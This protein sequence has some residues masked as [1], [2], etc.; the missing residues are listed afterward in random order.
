MSKSW[1]IFLLVLISVCLLP[2]KSWGQK[3]TTRLADKSFAEFAYME[4]IELYEYAYE[5]DTTDNYVV[6]QLAESNRNVGNTEEVEKWLKKLIDRRAEQPEDIFNYSQ[7]LKSNGKYLLAEQW[8]K[9]YSDLRPEDG[10]VNL[11]VSLLEYIQFLMRDSA[12]YEIRNLA[13]NTPGSEMGPA[14]YKNQFIFSSTSIGSKSGATYKWNELP[15]LDL[16]SAQINPGSGEVTNP[17]PFAPKLK[18]ALHD[19]PVSFDEKNDLIFL[20]RNSFVRGKTTKSSEGVVNLKIFQGKLEDDEWKLTGSFRYNSNEYSIGH[21]SID[22]NGTI[23]YFA[24]DMPGG[25]GKSD[26]YFSVLSNGQWSKPFNLGPK[27]NT[28]GNEFFPFISNDGVLYFASNGHGGLGGLDIYFSVPEQGV[29]NSIENLGYPTNSSKDDFG[30]VLDSTG[31][32]GY[33]ASNRPGGKG[34]DDLYFVKIKRV[35]VI[36]RGVVKDRDTKD[37]LTDAT[38]SV[39]DENGKTIVSSITRNDGQFEFE[40]NK[41]QQYIVHVKKEFYFENEKQIATSALR[42]NDEVFSEIFL[43]QEIEELDNSPAPIN[44]EEEDGKALQV[45]EIEYINYELDKADITP[46][47]EASLDKLI[48]LL[49]EFP[50]LEIRIE[51][52]TD[53][54]GSDDYNLLLSKRRAKA[55]YDYVISKGVDPM[56][57]LYQG[58]GET[59]LLNNCGNGVP[60]TEEQHEVNRR[61]IV[62]VV[63]KG[64]YKEKRNQRNIFY[65]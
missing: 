64:A 54:R 25:Y 62:K 34:N 35:P 11:Q 42:P 2:D 63:R 20:T 38:V 30:L 13:V 41:G 46:S 19:G 29:F 28:E 14:L 56:R 59:K 65:F 44:M 45:I 39:I 53:S 1:N 26:I 9:E 43:E 50:D 7:A 10:R 17:Q 21:P 37:V 6:K 33:F 12:N 49:K 23:L 32:K 4:A 16:Y 58:Y 60:C 57:L 55:A 5:R 3:I 61:S 8:L 31:M 47:A 15:Y 18:T 27:V 51:S 24:S 52:H 40:V 22:K 36:I 48:A